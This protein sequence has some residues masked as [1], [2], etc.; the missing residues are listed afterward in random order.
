MTPDCS[1]IG[2]LGLPILSHAGQQTDAQQVETLVQNINCS[3]PLGRLAVK[4]V[5]EAAQAAAAARKSEQAK[6]R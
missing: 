4:K 2:A 3:L 5:G 1:Y 6:D